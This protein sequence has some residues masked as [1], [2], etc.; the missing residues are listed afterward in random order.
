M[1]K[2]FNRIKSDVHI[3]L[4]IVFGVGAIYFFGLAVW[5]SQW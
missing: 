5:C 2:L 4:A 1:K 3:Q